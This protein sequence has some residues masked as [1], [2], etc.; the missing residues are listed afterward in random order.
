MDAV[1]EDGGE[2]T[3]FGPDLGW[4]VEEAERPGLGRLAECLLGIMSAL[5]APSLLDSYRSSLLALAALADGVRMCHCK[6]R[7]DGAKILCA[8]IGLNASF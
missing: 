4:E 7:G 8:T 6:W 5:F 1:G 2:A 3:N